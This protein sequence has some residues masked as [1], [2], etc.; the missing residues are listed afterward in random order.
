M[1]TLACMPERNE[2]PEKMKKGSCKEGENIEDADYRDKVFDQKDSVVGKP[3]T[4]F[5][6]VLVV[7]EKDLYKKIIKK[8][9]CG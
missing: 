3:E 8:Y 2:P 4:V 7:V 6:E 9:Y 5:V 1:E